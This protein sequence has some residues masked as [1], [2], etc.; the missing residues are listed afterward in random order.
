MVLYNFKLTTNRSFPIVQPDT[1]A[2]RAIVWHITTD[3]PSV[4]GM[5]IMILPGIT[6]L[7]TYMLIIYDYTYYSYTI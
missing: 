1:P 6:A 5:L 3:K 7:S 4:H 2:L